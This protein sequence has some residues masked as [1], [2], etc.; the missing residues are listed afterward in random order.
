MGQL[1]INSLIHAETT[2]IEDLQ[3]E[4]EEAMLRLRRLRLRKSSSVYDRVKSPLAIHDR[5]KILT[6]G[7]TAKAGTVAVVSRYEKRDD[8]DY[9]CY[10]A[11]TDDLSNTFEIQRK[12]KNLRKLPASR[13]NI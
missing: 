7:K 4:L 9:W 8:G 2:L 10:L 6:T 11:V 13:K 3:L 5:V 1:D 12:A